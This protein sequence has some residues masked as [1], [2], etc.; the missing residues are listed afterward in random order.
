MD[1]WMDRY[2]MCYAQSVA[3]GHYQG[4]TKR[5]PTT[6]ENYDSPLGTHSTVELNEPGRKKLGT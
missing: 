6:R 1:G 2:L 3:K 5:V 4:E